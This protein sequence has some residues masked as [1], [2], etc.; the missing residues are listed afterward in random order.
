MVNGIYNV[1]LFVV[2]ENRNSKLDEVSVFL[3]NSSN[4]MS[5]RSN[6]GV[7]EPNFFH[8]HKRGMLILTVK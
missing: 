1:F 8:M 5:I 6:S 3:S 7:C 2:T 4:L